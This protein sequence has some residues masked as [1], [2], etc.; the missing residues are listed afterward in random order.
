MDP[1]GGYQRQPLMG[2]FE[3]NSTAAARILSIFDFVA[4]SESAVDVASI[5]ERLALPKA[6]TYRLMDGLVN[7]GYLSRVPKK[8]T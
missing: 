5:V 3:T 1:R 4:R 2:P 7:S 8:R 6:T